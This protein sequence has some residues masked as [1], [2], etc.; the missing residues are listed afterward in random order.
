MITGQT[1]NNYLLERKLGE[2]G[3]GEVYYARHNRIERQVA[4][5][6]L[7]KNL[8][9]VETIRSRFKNEANALIKLE[10][11]NIVKIYD[12]IEHENFACLIVEYIDGITLD[13]YINKFSSQTQK[14]VPSCMPC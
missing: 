10:H 7:H 5:K 6:I 1:I 2:G 8:F 11:P 4:I 13:D 14:S 3:M 9:A 12:Y